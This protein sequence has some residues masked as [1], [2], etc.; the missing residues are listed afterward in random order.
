MKN[1]KNNAAL[2]ISISKA[3]D[4]PASDVLTE[5]SYA[6]LALSISTQEALAGWKR[7]DDAGMPCGLEDIKANY[8]ILL[9]D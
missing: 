3:I 2:A 8:R 6:A 5:A 4:C 1:Y 7:L 9:E